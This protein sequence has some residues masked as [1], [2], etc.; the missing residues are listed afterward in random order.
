MAGLYELSAEYEALLA[1]YDRFC[2]IENELT[3]VDGKFYHNGNLI[4]DVVQYKRN[5][6]TAWFDTLEG[7]EGEIEE[8]ILNLACYIKDLDSKADAIKAEKD[9]LA[10]RQKTTES[11]A[12]QLREYIISVMQT[13]DRKKLESSQAVVSLSAGCESVCISDEKKFIEWAKVNCDDLLNYKQ[14]DISKTA[15]KAAIKSGEKVPFASLEKI[16]T[17]TIK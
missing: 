16:P 3:E 17:I 8:K 6:I 12:R 15:V 11:K 9:R 13:L 4:D 10:A 5:L 14:P 7:M 1:S 2:N